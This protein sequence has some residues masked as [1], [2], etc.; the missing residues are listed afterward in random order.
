M[1]KKLFF[2][3]NSHDKKFLFALLTFSIFIGFIESFA[4]SLIMPF[5]SVASNFELLEKSSYFRPIY[6]YLNLPS[7]KLVAYFG[8]ILIVFYIFRAF[9][10]AF[11]FHLLA[12]FSKGRYHTFACRIFNKYLHLEYENF[13]NKNQSE[14]LK[15]ITQEV[16]HLS[17]LIS[18]FLLMLS[19]SFVVFLL[20]TLLLI[21]NYKITL[22]LS[23]FLLLNAFILIK[24]LSPLVKKASFA[25]EEAM[26]NYFEILNA[27]LNNFKI[28]KL[29]TKE[30]STQKLYE[31]QSGLFAKANISNESMSSIPRIYLEG[32]GFC[33]LCLI[34]VYL[35][36]RYE[37]DIS[38]ILATI[39]IF[40]VALYRLMPSANRIITSYNE[41][42]YYR[43]SLD[44]IY[45]ILNEKEE[46]LGNENIEFEEKIELKDL[47]FAY[48]GKKNLF[49]GLNFT[50]QKNEKI[51]FIG[52]SGSGKSTLVDLIIGLLKP[53]DGA[54]FIDGIKLDENNIK[55][56]RSKI[57]YIPQQ[58]YLFNDSIA[59]N[60]S[61]GEEIDENLLKQVIKQ[62]N[63]ENFVNSLEH[64][65]HTKVGDS[66]SFLSGGQRQRIAIARAL[67]QQPQILV[68]DEATSALDQESE[69]K[70]MDEIYK[71]SQDK[72]LII[73]A[74]R[75][76]TIQKC[77]RVFEVDRGNLKEKK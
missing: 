7:Y 55:S 4:I 45:D 32:M 21:I 8:C 37:S 65:I 57:G 24:I 10:N 77:D 40:V 47:F 58:I 20:Y 3:L 43:N 63:L 9:L 67:Y 66:G 2:I 53:N 44:I 48:K 59:K 15:T 68:L 30:Q 39:T 17:T 64:G 54:I 14:L 28:I 31:I 6:E 42:I 26:K 73:I 22:A 11:Y 51:A 1:L 5:V 71:I 18:A 74:H 69:A 35:V 46:K 41:I 29:K 56:F 60:I 23:V 50:L 16:F 33:M 36:L 13:T 52:K 61:F 25:R 12:R 27:N 62:A 38:S 34:V 72:T 49:K 19:E 75:L 76:S 70:I